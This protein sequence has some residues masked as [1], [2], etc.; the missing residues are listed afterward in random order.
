MGSDSYAPSVRTD[1][2]GDMWNDL[3]LEFGDE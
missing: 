1:Q 3:V 2:A